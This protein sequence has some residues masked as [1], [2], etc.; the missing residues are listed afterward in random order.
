MRLSAIVPCPPFSGVWSSSGAEYDNRPEALLAAMGTAPAEVVVCDTV[1]GGIPDFTCRGRK[2]TIPA[3]VLLILGMVRSSAVS[4]GV[5]VSA[6]ILV[7]SRYHFRG[8]SA[9]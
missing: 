9:L 2:K 8:F 7:S 5:A 1:A 4:A 3:A 6:V